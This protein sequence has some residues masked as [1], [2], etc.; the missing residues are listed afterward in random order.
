MPLFL[1]YHFI[2]SHN[3]N[4]LEGDA[5]E[6]LPH[7]IPLD[8]GLPNTFPKEMHISVG[9]SYHISISQ[10][11]GACRIKVTHIKALL[12][13]L[14]S[15]NLCLTNLQGTRKWHRDCA[16]Q[17]A[18]PPLVNNHHLVLDQLFKRPTPNEPTVLNKAP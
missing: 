17:N 13:W 18:C 6:K 15:H 10:H 3:P 9:G 4:G 14:Q 16:G 11:V 12:A 7:F 5:V 8:K 2:I 1:V